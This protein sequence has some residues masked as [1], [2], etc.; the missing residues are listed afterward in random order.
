VSARR[1]RCARQR[2]QRQ[3]RQLRGRVAVQAR[4]RLIAATEVYPNA[5]T[6]GVSATSSSWVD[7]NS[8]R[9]ASRYSASAGLGRWT[10]G[11]GI[12][13]HVAAEEA[14]SLILLIGRIDTLNLGRG[15][16]QETD[17]SKAFSGLLKW[18]G[19]LDSADGAVEV[20]AR[21]RRC[22]AGDPR[23]GIRQLPE[24]MLTNL[25]ERHKASVHGGSMPLAASEDPS[26]L[27]A[28]LVKA[29]RPALIEDA[30]SPGSAHPRQGTNPQ[31]LSVHSRTRTRS[32]VI[33]T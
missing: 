16:V 25:V 23:S 30:S 12:G 3:R 4:Y 2:R 27:P 5:V 28:M 1:W 22:H 33:S 19:R 6:F 26:A 20:L 18:S 10:Q 9:L 32:V 21:F 14:V 29:E 17:S 8:V 24:D 31:H 7:A 13:G 15:A 11:A